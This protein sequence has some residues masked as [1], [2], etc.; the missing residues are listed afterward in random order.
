MEARRL[1]FVGYSLASADFEFRQL[2]SRMVH[3]E[4][5]IEV[6]LW[7]AAETFPEER[8]RYENFFSQHEVNV[9]GG[10]AVEFVSKEIARP[11]PDISSMTRAARS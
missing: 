8:K 3:R 9:F 7:G 10:G 5:T 2:L 1:V 11:V 4:A 6:F